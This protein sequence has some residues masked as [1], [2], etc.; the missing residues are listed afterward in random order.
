MKNRI[1]II[2]I[3]LVIL[4]QVKLIG[5]ETR[6]DTTFVSDKYKKS[7][8]KI[9]SLYGKKDF[10]KVIEMTNELLQGVHNLKN[11]DKKVFTYIKALVFYKQSNIDSALLNLYLAEQIDTPDLPKLNA[12][13]F[14]T[15]GSIN[16]SI[17]N[18][19]EALK[20]YLNAQ[21]INKLLKDSLAYSSTL[22]D[23]GLMYY[24]S[25]YNQ[26]AFEY[27]IK[28]INIK[29]ELK[30]T[31]SVYSTK[32][33]LALILMELEKGDEAIK[34]IKEYLDYVLK[35]DVGIQAQIMCFYN[36]GLAYHLKKENDSART[37]LEYALKMSEDLKFDF[38]IAKV[39]YAL[40]E[41]Y[42]ELKL[43]KNSYEYAQNAIDFNFNSVDFWGFTNLVLAHSK[44][45]LKIDDYEKHFQIV[46]DSIKKH[47]NKGL[48]KELYNKMLLISLDKED[49][50]NAYKYEKKLNKIDRD[51]QNSSLNLQVAELKI[52]SELDEQ[53]SELERLDLENK[54]KQERI[55]QRN[56]FIILLV[57]FV[58]ILLGVFIYI[59]FQNQKINSLN[60]KLKETNKTILKF[61]SIISHDLRS[62]VGSFKMILDE[63]NVNYEDYT[64][65]DKKRLI[66]ETTLEVNN[67]LRLLENLLTWAKTSKGEFNL[68]F[69]DVDVSNELDDISL[70]LKNIL[71]EKKLEID[72][73]YKENIVLS[74]DRDMFNTIIR[75]LLS[76][77]IKF[78]NHN[79]K[80]SLSA[81]QREDCIEISVADNGI[82][83]SEEQLNN[84]FK[85]D[86]KIT[87][88]GTNNERGSGLGLIIV[89]EL[90]ELMKGKIE[91]SSEINKGT[92]V[93][94]CLPKN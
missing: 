25:G 9:D 75:N 77:S 6:L 4:F 70:S 48:E 55:D 3:L 57:L 60:S 80:I 78:S 84:L 13:I 86:K 76:N 68:F 15:L 81:E 56:I 69:K 19:E 67:I 83:M 53:K 28:S 12:R 1:F 10:D 51:L 42:F 40:A 74:V 94:I 92:K 63:L 93:S 89:K 54:L 66:H 61:F 85:I 36:L 45:K 59:F 62:P 23:I 88:P 24:Y 14:V 5:F 65:E 27:F 73:K 64:E 46:L 38:G 20:N 18:Y 39:K 11:N 33:N 79:S 82:G 29:K 87:R 34:Y 50:K 49:F 37:N 7:F 2:S 58:F 47:P 90:V 52:Q 16:T 32:M 41:I 35:N 31:Q 30:D 72:K 43:Y 22:N 26:K 44:Y 8:I 71:K 91:V 21:T 17:S